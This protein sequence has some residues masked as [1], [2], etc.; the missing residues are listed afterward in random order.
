MST[1]STQQSFMPH[2]KLDHQV[3]RQLIGKPTRTFSQQRF[4]LHTGKQHLLLDRRTNIIMNDNDISGANDPLAR[5][6]VQN[7]RILY[8][9]HCDYSCKTNKTHPSAAKATSANRPKLIFMIDEFE[10]FDPGLLED[11]IS[12]FSNLIAN[13]PIMLVLS[14]NTSAEAIHSLLPRTSVFRLKMTPFAVDMGGGAVTSLI[15]Q[16]AFDPD[17]VFDL[18]S[19]VVRF[20]M[21]S[22]ERLNKSI[23]NLIAKLQFIH[24]A[25]F[26]TNP[27][28]GF[29]DKVSMV[30]KE[31][32]QDD[33]EQPSNFEYLAHHLRLTNSWKRARRGQTLL[34]NDQELI[35]ILWKS[36]RRRKQTRESCLMA[37]ETLGR[38][39]QLWP[40]KE[41]TPEWI[42]YNV[43]RPQLVDYSI[44]MC[45]LIKHSN[46]EMLMTVLNSLS[47]MTAEFDWLESSLIRL[48][49][50]MNDTEV[51]RAGARTHLVNTHEPMLAGVVLLP[52][53]REFTNLISDITDALIQYFRNNLGADSLLELHEAWTFDDKILLN[54]VFHPRYVHQ[55]KSGLESGSSAAEWTVEEEGRRREMEAEEEDMRRLRRMYGLYMETDG[56]TI[57]L[58]DWF[59]AFCQQTTSAAVVK[60][61]KSAGGGAQ[62]KR[63]KLASNLDVHEEEEDEGQMQR[64]VFV[65]ALADLAFLGLVSHAGRKK[66][67]VSK[68]FFG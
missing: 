60:D 2:S 36:Y 24:L 53:D 55:I 45:K 56:K 48:S 4:S 57:N 44:E 67:H 37:L 11:L 6:D 62:K 8:Q 40:E 35:H 46:D 16:I 34:V 38:I 63:K 9:A 39:G 51:R 58:D 10:S 1:H 26:H 12:I 13:I 68:S 66:E 50:L 64:V 28:C 30:E 54:E 19:G 7:I 29:F 25:H 47:D 42:L 17:S 43:H 41:R 31:K 33:I 59:G 23:D 15:Q 65:R 14:L 61:A 49:E 27:L 52:A 32:E 22:Y 5:D 21:D 20:L 18:S 3:Y